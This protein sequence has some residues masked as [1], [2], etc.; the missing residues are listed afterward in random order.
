MGA[1]LTRL[2]K[3]LS[4]RG[5]C[6]RREVRGA[7]A[8]IQ[9]GGRPA[10]SYDE[11]VD[12][13]EVTWDGEP[14]DPETLLILLHK[15]AGYTC[16]HR[17]LPPLVFELLP[18]RWLRRNPAL[19]SVGRLDKDTT[20]V[21]L[22]TDDGALLHRLTSPKARLPKI[23]EVTLERKPTDEELEQV[24]AGGLILEDKPLL[25]A[26]VERSGPLQVRLELVE[27]RYHQIKRTFALLGNAVTRLHRS[28][29][30]EWT[31]AGLEPAEYRIL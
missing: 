20:G 31:V 17:D 13:A 6:T 19:N 23:Y 25:P 2:D 9:V 8:R 21:L 29:V 3:L 30:G 7:G 1:P 15:P 22:L 16:S 4:Q 14:L 12:P 5:Y 11:K 28:R 18:E 24:R 26:P 10:R 27:G